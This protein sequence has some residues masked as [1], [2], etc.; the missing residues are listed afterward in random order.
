MRRSGSSLFVGACY[1]Q[2][3]RNASVG[4]LT[5]ALAVVPPLPWAYASLRETN[6]AVRERSLLIAP[7]TRTYPGVAANARGLI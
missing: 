1:S 4:N 3:L 7:P 5:K 2:M 6:V